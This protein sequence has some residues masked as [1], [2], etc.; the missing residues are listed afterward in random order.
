MPRGRR[1]LRPAVTEDR[2]SD[3]DGNVMD[4]GGSEGR[5]RIRSA[6]NHAGNRGRNVVRRG[7]GQIEWVH[8]IVPV[9]EEEQEDTELLKSTILA[10]KSWDSYC[11]FLVKFACFVAEKEPTL[12]TDDLKNKLNAI[13]KDDWKK[14]IKE[15]CKRKPK[16]ATP[17]FKLSQI[18]DIFGHWV[19][20]MKKKDGSDLSKSSYN[21][22]RS[23]VVALF[24]LFNV[25][26]ETFDR[27]AAAI[28]RGLKVRH[29]NSAAMGEQSVKRGKDPLSFENYKAIA[30]SLLNEEDF[31]S[32]FS[33]TVLTTM[34]NLM[35]RV[36]NAVKICKSHLQ[37]DQDALLIYFA[38]EKTD[39]TQSRPG[40]PRHIYANPF[41]PEICPILSLGL[42]FL[43]VDITATDSEP[44]FTGSNQYSRFEKSLQK[45][46]AK[47]E[48]L[49]HSKGTFGTHSIRK[50]SATYASSGTTACPPYAA[51]SL[52]AGWSMGNVSSIYIQYQNAGDQHVGRTV[53]GLDPSTPSFA[54]L[55]PR[56]KTSYDPTP[57]LRSLF[58]RF[59]DVTP[60]LRRVLTMTTASVVYNMKWLVDNLPPEHPIFS[61]NI[62]RR[63]LPLPADEMVECLEMTDIGIAR[64]GDG[65][66]ATGIPPHVSLLISMAQLLRC[67]N[68]MPASIREMMNQRIDV[69]HDF[70][71]TAPAEQVKNLLVEAFRESLRKDNIDPVQ[72]QANNPAGASLPKLY[73]TEKN[74]MTRLPPDFHLPRGPLKSAWIC[75]CCWDERRQIPPLRAVFGSEMKRSLS[76]RFAQYRKLMEAIVN[77]AK[78]QNVW[79]EPNDAEM[80]IRILQRV[81]LN[82]IVPITT[83]KHRTRR[84]EQL[85]WST[86]AKDY[87]RTQQT[88]R[89]QLALQED[90]E[91]GDENEQG[92]DDDEEEEE[93]EEEDEDEDD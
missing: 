51:V 61:T 45:Q 9:T 82:E 50:G 85:S 74:K 21:T 43:V 6:V 36:G 73:F 58:T 76:S 10:E 30:R 4:H 91:E 24:T 3:A 81:S 71:R 93:E 13:P 11:T 7:E 37:W 75:Y 16:P 2:L 12:L 39:Q 19:R 32:L 66:V 5:V 22:C 90:E 52:R 86:L 34:W 20:S 89:R 40:D 46:Y 49:G 48:M 15:Y 59:D 29:A 69:Q 14:C 31:H 56:F 92:D 47:E 8:P 53:C 35:S 88:L 78:E 60:E 80:A 1:R 62:F 18:T 83:H 41:C 54:V 28:L 27:N 63:R 67:M 25:P 57:L 77:K 55:P 87:Y 42:F 84:L 38:H 33:H 44:I 23:A 79:E 70:L 72:V 17:L 26:S 68:E 64:Q 65:F